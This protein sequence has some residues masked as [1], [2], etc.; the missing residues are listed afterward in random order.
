MLAISFAGAGGDPPY[1]DIAEW[2]VCVS[3]RVLVDEFEFE[4][5][6]GC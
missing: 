2:S 5:D 4:E 6:R 1:F 3:E